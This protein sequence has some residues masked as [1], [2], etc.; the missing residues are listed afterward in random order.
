MD[1]GVRPRFYHPMD[2]RAQ[3]SIEAHIYFDKESTMVLQLDRRWAV[4]VNGVLH[5]Y[6][7]SP[8]GADLALRSATESAP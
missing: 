3:D 5:S 2:R 6:H 7:D 4:Y 8:M 1:I